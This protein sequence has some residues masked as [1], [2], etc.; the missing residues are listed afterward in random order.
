MKTE[1]LEDMGLTRN[2]AAIYLALL[3]LGSAP[4]S[5]IA[6]RTRLN[7][8]NMY[9]T[10]S[11]LVRKGLISH[12]IRNNVKHFMAAKPARL[13]EI[14]REKEEKLQLMLPQLE[15][16]E[17]IP[18]KIKVEIYEEKEGVK[19]FFSDMA[20]TTAEV[21]AFGVTGMAYDVL[22]Y[23]APKVLKQM[24]EKTKGRYIV[25]EEARGKE[26][27]TLPNTQFRYLPA[28]Y[29]NYATTI[30]YHNKVAIL[31]LKD[32][33]RVIMIDDKMIAEGYRKYFEFMWERA[34]R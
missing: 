15:S 16:I 24:A 19:A 5:G 32:K 22:K 31:V 18:E 33:P 10:I 34:E 7:R 29:S 4:V 14:L 17:K 2:E 6:E 1:V 23:Y 26:I 13:M 28:K 3:E 30:I 9:N 25:I 27:T 12:I 8:A 21:L 11:S 20:K